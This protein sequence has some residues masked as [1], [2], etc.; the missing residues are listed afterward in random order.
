MTISVDSAALLSAMSSLAS[1][2]VESFTKPA[3][4]VTADRVASE[5]ERRVLRATGETARGIVALESRDGAG[6]VVTSTNERMPNLPTWLEFGTKRGKSG[7]HAEP[8]HPYL[9]ASARLEESGHD[10]RMREAVQDAIDSVGLG[11]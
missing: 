9:F 5:A 6:Y 7:S 8:A 3:A 4:K 11:E 2:V 1:G 10:A